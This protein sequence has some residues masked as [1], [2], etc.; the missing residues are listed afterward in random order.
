MIIQIIFYLWYSMKKYKNNK[1]SCISERKD[2]HI[3]NGRILWNLK[4]F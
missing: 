4:K 1:V 3:V 2:K